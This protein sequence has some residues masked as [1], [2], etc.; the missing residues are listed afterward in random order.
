MVLVLFIICG[1]VRYY[2]YHLWWSCV[3]GIIV[4][5]FVFS[6]FRYHCDRVFFCWWVSLLHSYILSYPILLYPMTSS[7]SHLSSSF[8]TN[9]TLSTTTTTATITTHH[10]ILIM[11]MTV[12]SSSFT[13]TPPQHAHHHHH[14]QPL[15]ERTARGTTTHHLLGGIEVQV[16]GGADG[17]EVLARVPGHMQGLLAELD[18]VGVHLHWVLVVLALA[19]LA[20]A[21]WQLHLVRQRRLLFCFH[22]VSDSLSKNREGLILLLLLLS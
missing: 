17:N 22:C 8:S 12:S 10:F 4:I 5:W 21:P 7:S 9:E 6:S 11:I 19:V 20:L 13:I 14:H 2:Y 3:L 1:L 16:V 18:L 15:N